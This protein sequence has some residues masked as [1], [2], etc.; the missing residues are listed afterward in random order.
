MSSLDGLAPVDDEGVSDHEA[1]RVGA[2]PDDR[3]GIS[4][5]RPILPIGSSA[6]TL[7]RP[8][9][10]PPVSGT[11]RFARRPRTRSA[12]AG[13]KGDCGCLVAPLRVWF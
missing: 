8:S 4:S 2:H 5:R 9:G 3:R 13:G 12:S 7:A 11:D 1:A 10:V 6:I